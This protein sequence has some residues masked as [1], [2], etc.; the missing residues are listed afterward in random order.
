MG[1]ATAHVFL[2]LQTEQSGSEVG[3]GLVGANKRHHACHARLW[4]NSTVPNLPNTLRSSLGHVKI[5]IN[6]IKTQS[7]L[8]GSC[9]TLFA[10]WKS[11][12]A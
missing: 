1:E 5:I 10:D 4:L 3:L 8:I 11:E 7:Q 12:K 2:E 9:V 6:L